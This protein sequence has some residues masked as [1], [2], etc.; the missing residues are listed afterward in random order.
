MITFV[1]LFIAAFC[2]GVQNALAGGG[3]FLTF[4][5]LMFTGLDAR[6][7]N[8]TST[9]ALFPGQITT[10][11]AGRQHVS[12]LPQLSF[13]ALFVI[14]LIGGVLG[15]LLLL[16]TP[17]SVFEFLVPWLVLFA[18][19]VFLWGSFFRRTRENSKQLG[20][21][22]AIIAQ[23]AISIYGGYFGGGIGILMLAALTISGLAVR[24]AGATK[25]VLAGVMNASAVLIFLFSSN[26]AWTQ[27]M[28]ASIASIAGGQV[29]ALALQRLN[30]KL[31]RV[32]I[33]ILGFG[34]TIGL[35]MKE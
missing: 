33:I 35:F 11:F 24:N 15:A 29:G 25:N 13:K 16:A 9:V 28:I 5:A 34:L 20:P 4:P 6:A 8:I 32:C 3:S 2:A 12:D 10:G 14:S 18:T 22:G 17:V 31:L 23:F 19:L 26:V 1:V 7:A 30:E 27:V 21:I